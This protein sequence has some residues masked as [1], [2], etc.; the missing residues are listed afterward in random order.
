MVTAAVRRQSVSCLR[1]HGRRESV[2]TG[3]PTARARSVAIGLG[4][5]RRRQRP[6][7]GGGGGKTTGGLYGPRT[8]SP[9]PP[10]PPSSP[11]PT[12]PLPSGVNR[13]S[14]R[15]RFSSEVTINRGG[16]SSS[17]NTAFGIA[18]ACFASFCKTV[19]FGVPNGRRAR[20]K[21]TAANAERVCGSQQTSMG[22]SLSVVVNTFS[23]AT[24]SDGI[25]QDSVLSRRIRVPSVMVLTCFVRI[26][27][28][29][30]KDGENH[31]GGG[32]SRVVAVEIIDS[33]YDR[34]FFSNG[35]FVHRSRPVF[36]CAKHDRFGSAG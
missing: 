7:P 5:P 24:S 8:R 34:R 17:D 2:T 6:V 27:G 29:E 31:G 35:R 9:P 10:P 12:L 20:V 15:R 13:V 16:R 36:L 30:N 22:K 4:R 23:P 1:T 32:V 19:F 18:F 25:S 21:R 14:L 11:P 33:S 26:S 3:G 28:V